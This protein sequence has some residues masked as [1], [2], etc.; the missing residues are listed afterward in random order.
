MD[1]I[2]WDENHHFSPP[3]GEVD[4][5]FFQASNNQLMVGWWFGFLGTPYLLVGGFNPFEKYQSKWESSPNRGENK[6]TFETTT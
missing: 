3:F 6:H 1:S 4:F 5:Y 2:P